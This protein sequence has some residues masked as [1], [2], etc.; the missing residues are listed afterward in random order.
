MSW[1]LHEVLL[2]KWSEETR[3]AIVS[4]IVWE[5]KRLP[6]LDYSPYAEL[7]FDRR[8]DEVCWQ[9][10]RDTGPHWEQ[11]VHEI[12][13]MVVR[14]LENVSDVCK[15]AMWLE[16][17]AG[18][19]WFEFDLEEMKGW[20]AARAMPWMESEIA[21]RIRKDVLSAAG[22]GTNHRLRQAMDRGYSG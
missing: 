12:D 8:W 13:R 14:R 1:T 5:L 6:L 3:D 4:Q 7:G 10:Q 20:E 9:V 21:E 17:A 16:T 22:A 15:K 11:H 19:Y 18:E 2:S